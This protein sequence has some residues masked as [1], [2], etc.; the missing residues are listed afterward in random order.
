MQYDFL[1]IYGFV[2]DYPKNW[3]VEL[4]PESDRNR[5][6]IV[7]RSPTMGNM[8]VSWEI[9]ERVKGRYNSITEQMNDLLENIKKSRGVKYVEVIERKEVEINGHKG[10][11]THFK[12]KSIRSFF[13]KKRVVLQELWSLLVYCEQT[14]RFF[15]L[16]G[17]L[18]SYEKSSEQADIFRHMQKT[19]RCHAE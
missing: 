9:L 16:H 17:S 3:K 18:G 2:V 19:F 6:N 15:A 12:V 7:F 5:G 11:Y 1:S 14:A 13:F 8:L 10:V 4:K